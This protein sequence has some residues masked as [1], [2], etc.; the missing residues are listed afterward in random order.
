MGNLRAL[1]ARLREVRS[2]DRSEHSHGGKRPLDNPD[3]LTAAG[4][5]DIQRDG[6][7]GGMPPASWVKDY[8]DGRPRT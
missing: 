8:D 5:G 1:V 6:E 3:A 7:F 4:A 2:L